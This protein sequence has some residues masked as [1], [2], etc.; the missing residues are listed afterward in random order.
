ML[1][2][3][4]YTRPNTYR[5]IAARCFIVTPDA[6]RC[7]LAQISPFSTAIFPHAHTYREPFPSLPA[8]HNARRKSHRA[9]SSHH[10]KIA[11][12]LELN[13][14]ASDVSSSPTEYVR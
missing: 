5:P 9:H 6:R 7:N 13:I 4:S 11:S 8:K 12:H 1:A 3:R 14:V 10:N 2:W